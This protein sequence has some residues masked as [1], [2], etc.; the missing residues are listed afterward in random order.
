M[1][2]DNAE[3]T[4]LITIMRPANQS[5]FDIAVINLILLVRLLTQYL[6]PFFASS[7]EEKSPLAG[8]NAGNERKGDLFT[9]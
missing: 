4:Y 5:H 1:F 6:V 3:R 7:F 8:K 2:R 9:A